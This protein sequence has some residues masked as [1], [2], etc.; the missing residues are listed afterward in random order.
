M[1]AFG[2]IVGNTEV[3]AR[4]ESSVLPVTRPERFRAARPPL[5]ECIGDLSLF[6]SELH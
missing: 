6:E 5:N 2:C 4:L 1:I 3:W